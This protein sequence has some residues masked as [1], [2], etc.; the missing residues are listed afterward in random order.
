[1][2]EARRAISRPAQLPAMENR[3]GLINRLNFSADFRVCCGVQ[4]SR[5][6]CRAIR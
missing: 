2:D 4:N 1:M 5:L 6:I 3:F